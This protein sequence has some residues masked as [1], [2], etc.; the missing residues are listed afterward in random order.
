MM[1]GKGEV[2]FRRKNVW[3]DAGEVAAD[4]AAASIFSLPRMPRWLGTHMKVILAR[5]EVRGERRV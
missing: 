1:N 4:F 5:M 2:R 3:L